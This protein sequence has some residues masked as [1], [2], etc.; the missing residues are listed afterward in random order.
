MIAALNPSSS[1][2]ETTGNSAYALFGICKRIF[3]LQRIKRIIVVY[4]VLSPNYVNIYL[5][6]TKNPTELVH[7][8]EDLSA[9]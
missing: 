4:L 6:H 5:T 7:C 1:N 2:D 9:R 8:T 3:H